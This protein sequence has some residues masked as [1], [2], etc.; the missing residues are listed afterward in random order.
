MITELV[1]VLGRSAVL[2]NEVFELADVLEVIDVLVGMA[3][4]AFEML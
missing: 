2:V 3:L 4:E 1:D